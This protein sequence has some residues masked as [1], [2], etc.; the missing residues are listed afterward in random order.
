[1]RRSSDARTQST[2]SRCVRG[3]D[4]EIVDHPADRGERCSRRAGLSVCNRRYIPRSTRGPRVGGPLSCPFWDEGSLGR[5][6]GDAA[7][8]GT[9]SAHG[10]VDVQVSGCLNVEL[11][12]AVGATD[13]RCNN[14]VRITPL[15]PNLQ[16]CRAREPTSTDRRG[17]CQQCAHPVKSLQRGVSDRYPQGKTDVH[18]IDRGKHARNPKSRI[19]AKH[20][21]ASGSFR[22][23]LNGAGG[24]GDGFAA[25]ST[26]E[27][28]A[29]DHHR[30]TSGRRGSDRTERHLVEQPDRVSLSLAALQRQW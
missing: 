6:R 29:S 12:H 19:H 1:M 5:R 26:R 30:D 17:K 22:A 2:S 18:A 16:P 25:G 7:E 11:D 9:V 13:V 4:R 14:D 23:R 15:R 10:S 8:D 27:R 3:G 24:S 28:R 21:R 20:G